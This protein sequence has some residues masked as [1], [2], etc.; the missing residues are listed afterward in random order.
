MLGMLDLTTVHDRKN[1]SEN[2][3][4]ACPACLRTRHMVTSAVSTALDQV[5]VRLEQQGCAR[6]IRH[7]N[8]LLEV[9]D[10]IPASTTDLIGQGILEELR[11]GLGAGIRMASEEPHSNPI[12][13]FRAVR[14][15]WLAS[16]PIHSPTM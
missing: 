9:L 6:A 3:Q 14:I 1:P 2:C 8:M 16:G 7:S 5:I 13:A 4:A 12:E 10:S 15:A 11:K